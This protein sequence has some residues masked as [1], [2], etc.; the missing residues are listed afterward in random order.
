MCLELWVHCLVVCER[1]AC[2]AGGGPPQPPAQLPMKLCPPPPPPAHLRL[3][4]PTFPFLPLSSVGALA[5]TLACIFFPCPPLAPLRAPLPLPYQ[6]SPSPP[7]LSLCF[8]SNC[9]PIGSGK[10]VPS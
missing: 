4:P 9:Q 2:V 8:L 10:S 3:L 1:P 6:L 5:H 7:V